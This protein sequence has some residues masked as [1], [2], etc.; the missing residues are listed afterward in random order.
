MSQFFTDKG[1]S[2]VDPLTR[3]GAVLGLAIL[4]TAV[5]YRGLDFVGKASTLMFVLTMSPFLIMV[6][7]GLAKGELVII[8]LHS[9]P[10]WAN[11]T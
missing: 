11:A 3:Y 1:A 5:N 4:L 2:E 6:V 8:N 10:R 9:S 7:V